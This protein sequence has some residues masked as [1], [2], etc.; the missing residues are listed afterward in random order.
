MSGDAAQLIQQANEC[1]V[2]EQFEAALSLYSRALALDHA[3]AS[4]LLRRAQCFERLGRHAHAVEDA[5]NAIRLDPRNDK[6][7]MRKATALFAAREFDASADAFRVARQLRLDAGESTAALDE[8]LA[9][10]ERRGG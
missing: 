9:K 10:C 2:D 4:T 5:I 7:H 3:S 6:A 1:F 8:W